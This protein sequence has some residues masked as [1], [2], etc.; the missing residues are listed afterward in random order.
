MEPARVP[1]DEQGEH[2]H[3]HEQ[4][5]GEPPRRPPWETADG[6]LIAV[7]GQIGVSCSIFRCILIEKAAVLRYISSLNIKIW[8]VRG[9]CT[10]KRPVHRQAP[11]APA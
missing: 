4:Q 5:H 1:E 8:A 11:G 9:W 7:G 3:E 2:E 10:G 6:S